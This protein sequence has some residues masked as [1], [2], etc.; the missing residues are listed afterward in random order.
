MEKTGIIR[1]VDELGR[2]V[3]PKEMR[4][5]MGVCEGDAFEIA[6]ENG[7]F[8]LIPKRTTTDQIVHEIDTLMNSLEDIDARAELEILEQMRRHFL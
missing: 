4:N 7:N 5:S 8:V 1:R 6:V 2:I 3:I